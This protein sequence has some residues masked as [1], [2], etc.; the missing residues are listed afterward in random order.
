M[1]LSPT[2]R[3]QLLQTK[4]RALIVENWNVDPAS[5]GGEAFPIGAGFVAA[6][7]GVGWVLV[8]AITIDADPLDAEALRP[9]LAAGWLGG[10]VVWRQRHGLHTLNVLCDLADG[11][12]ARRN[13]LLGSPLGL[14]VVNGRQTTPMIAEPFVP[15]TQPDAVTMVHVDTITACG[16]DAVVEHGV[17]RAELLGLEVA[18]V[19]I[20]QHD[21]VARLHVG[22]G[23]H[24][25]L[26]QS[27]MHGSEV[28][29]V[30][31][32]TEAVGAVRAHRRIDAGS[33]PANQLSRER[34]FRI[35]LCASP[36]R[37]G[38]VSLTPTESTVVPTLKLATPAMAV[39]RADDGRPMVV[40]AS[41]G[42]DL[43]AALVVADVAA[44]LGLADAHRVLVVPN[45]NDL[46]AVR[47]V[48]DA[49]GVQTVTA[50]VP[51]P[52]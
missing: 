19:M 35:A 48:A 1:A 40:G 27:M 13:M 37:I 38:A 24:D 25:R 18:R 33:H 10:A 2:Q 21:G 6:T 46:P 3:A 15:A 42:V 31:G 12:G 16:A 36:D 47:R 26:A 50:D 4:L 44:V 22:V 17:L 28:D 5:L 30:V 34:W 41:A 51:W 14:F 52:R 49:C 7:T 32:L 45:G 43:D 11:G 20:D 23:K 29:S 8:P 39:G 9:A